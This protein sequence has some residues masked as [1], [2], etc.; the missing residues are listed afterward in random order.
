MKTALLTLAVTSLCLSIG[1]AEADKGKNKSVTWKFD[2]LKRIGGHPVQVLGKP[3][4]INTS[5]GKAIAFDGVDDGLFFDVHPLA[6]LSKF[7]VEVI[8]RPDADGPK[9]QRFFHMQEA[10][11]ENR[12][13]FETRVTDDGRW[14]LDTFIKSGEGNYTQ[15][16][17]QHKHRCD[18]WYHAA[19]V[20]DGS[21]MRH[22]VDGKLELT[23]KID[24]T[25]QQQGRTSL[26][27]RQNK[28][29][30]FKGAI[31]TAR[32]TPKSLSTQQFLKAK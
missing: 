14:Y 27:V 24:Y 32:F 16:A 7:T 9:E 11:T 31:R 6:G 17:E 8:F 21:E 22:Y 23:T 5:A 4:V 2:N 10:K 19:L 18:R 15:L 29:F 12:V 1:H 13:M 25:P 30:W 28:V 20:V 26:G 3:R